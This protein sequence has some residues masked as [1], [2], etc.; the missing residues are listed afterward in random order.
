MKQQ[1]I[2]GK[3]WTIMLAGAALGAAAMYLS[4]PRL[5]RRRR[6]QLFDRLQSMRTGA[7]GAG[8]AML[9]DAGN[10]LGGLRAKL[11][12]AWQGEPAQATE[13]VL[14]A[15]VRA[16]LG[17][18]VSHPHAIK[19][20]AV[21]SRL[22][23]SGTILADERQY[24][25]EQARKTPGVSEVEDFLTVYATSRGVPALQGHRRARPRRDWLSLLQGL[26]GA[27]SGILGAWRL[28]RRMPS[29]LLLAGAGA[30]LLMRARAARTAKPEP[31][32]DAAAA[33]SHLEQ[34]I[35]VQATP[36]AVFDAW[37]DFEN[38]PHFMSRLLA[39]QGLE[40]DRSHWIVQA[41]ENERM[42]WD[43][44]WAERTRPAYLAWRGEAAGALEHVG[45]VELRPVRNGTLV[46]V[47]LSWRQPAGS[48]GEAMTHVP[49][50]QVRQEL[51]ADLVRMKSFIE[52]GV[53]PHHNADAS[54][55]EGGQMLH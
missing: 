31:L 13:D 7:V 16:R 33:V 36:E 47:S 19:V 14:S 48:A 55:P 24:L 10:R 4:D 28:A 52:S 23:L 20:T 32:T 1:G 50:E 40:E 11:L 37:S 46:T 15:R 44:E 39:V 8:D 9:H 5:G 54:R 29:G 26:G 17:R 35:E 51:Q 49:G 2:A 6:A 27:S 18:L 22:I 53:V 30:A 3:D 43:V 21:G 38:F 25:L 12:D 41:G 42:E 34:S 45:S